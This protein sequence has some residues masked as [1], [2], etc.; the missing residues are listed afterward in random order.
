ME[1]F[2]GTAALMRL[3]NLH[4]LGSAFG[5]LFLFLPR[6]NIYKSRNNKKWMLTCALLGT[7][8]RWRL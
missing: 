3:F 2:Q 6:E 5:K 4:D 8:F 7:L 1:G